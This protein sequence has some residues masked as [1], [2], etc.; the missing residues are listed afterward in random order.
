MT[1]SPLEKVIA[2]CRKINLEIKPVEI[3]GRKLF[4]YRPD[5]CLLRTFDVYDSGRIDA[6][7]FANWWRFMGYDK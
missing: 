4:L 5:G 2:A 7:D 3:G 6:D 1:L